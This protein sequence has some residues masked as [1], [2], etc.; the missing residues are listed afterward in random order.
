MRGTLGC[1]PRPLPA[2]SNSARSANADPKEEPQAAPG[3]FQLRRHPLPRRTRAQHWKRAASGTERSCFTFTTSPPGTR[4][5]RVPLLLVLHPWRAPSFSSPSSPLNSLSH[6][7]SA[8]V[9]QAARVSHETHES[10]MLLPRWESQSRYK[11]SP[12]FHSSRCLLWHFCWL[13]QPSEKWSRCSRQQSA[14]NQAA[15]IQGC[16]STRYCFVQC[17]C[18]KR[19]LVYTWYTLPEM[20]V[21]AKHP[22]FPKKK[23]QWS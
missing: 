22:T 1:Q 19:A 21:N 6:A 15:Q 17:Q 7:T 4:E 3:C 2:P 5:T 8:R 18:P 20:L 23:P 13:P 9:F 10:H 12:H 11:E 16:T 14:A